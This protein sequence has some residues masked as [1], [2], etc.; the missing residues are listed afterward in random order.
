MTLLFTSA[1]ECSHF[2][3]HFP[4]LNRNDFSTTF[5]VTGNPIFALEVTE[6]SVLVL[7]LARFVANA[8]I[9]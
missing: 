3:H 6:Y 5:H 2:L 4:D 9:R 8:K 7:L 1:L